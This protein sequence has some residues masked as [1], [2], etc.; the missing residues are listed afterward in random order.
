MKQF[1]WFMDVSKK[2][3]W[4]LFL[5][6]SKLL[7]R[8]GYAI[9]SSLNLEMSPLS[10]GIVSELFHIRPSSGFSPNDHQ[11]FALINGLKDQRRNKQENSTQT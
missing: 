5:T 7:Q 8:V 3:S 10:L 9:T 6:F 4:Q 11:N 2:V 1:E